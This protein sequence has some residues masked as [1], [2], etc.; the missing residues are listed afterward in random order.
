LTGA[1]VESEFRETVRAVVPL[2]HAVA[3]DTAAFLARLQPFGPLDLMVLKATSPSHASQLRNFFLGIVGGGA[4]IDPAPFANAWHCGPP[5]FIA[6]RDTMTA[7]LGAIRVLVGQF[8]AMPRVTLVAAWPNGGFRAG[9]LTYDGREFRLHTPSPGMGFVPWRSVVVPNDAAA[10][11]SAL[12]TTRAAVEEI[13]GGL[14]AA[15]LA[16]IARDGSGSVR[17]VLAGGIS[18]NEAGLLFLGPTDQAPSRE[19]ALL[20]GREYVGVEEIA[21]R[22]FFYVTT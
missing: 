19:T 10:E 12:G 1:Q 13:V 16:A 11:F 8:D 15:G 22:V 21:A 2:A 18:D 17:V 20:D 7:R 14:R 4:G 9:L 6:R 3:G 5:C